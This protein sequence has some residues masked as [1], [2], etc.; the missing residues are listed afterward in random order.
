MITKSK[1]QKCLQ[2]LRMSESMPTNLDDFYIE[3]TISSCTLSKKTVLESE[4]YLSV[5][6][7]T[8]QIY[9]ISPSKAGIYLLYDLHKNPHYHL[10]HKERSSVQQK[11]T[12]LGVP[13]VLLDDKSY[14]EEGR[15]HHHTHL[16]PLYKEKV[17]PVITKLDLD[18]IVSKLS[19][20]EICDRGNIA[21]TFGWKNNAFVKSNGV[22]VPCNDTLDDFDRTVLKIMTKSYMSAYGDNIANP[23]FTKNE[24]RI[25]EY[26]NQLVTIG[27]CV[28]SNSSIENVFES[29]TYALTFCSNNSNT[30]LRPH[31]DTLNC[32][33]TGFNAVF[34]M[35]F[36][37]RHPTEKKF[38][39]L[40][41]LGYSRRSIFYAMN[42]F[43]K[44]S[45][46]KNHLK[47]YS[48]YLDERN[49][50]CLEN[51]IPWND[52]R[53]KTPSIISKIPFIDKC[54]F[55]SIFVSGLYDII[56][57]G[58][59]LFL[60]DIVELVL[61]IGWLCT[62]ANYY[63][64]LS[65]WNSNGIPKGNLTVIM[66]R[67]LVEQF[68]G[69]SRGEGLRMQPSC[70]SP[71]PL[72]KIY[73]GQRILLR[74]INIA[75]GSP[76]CDIKQGME[77][78]EK[79]YYVRGLGAQHLMSV[80]TLLRVVYNPEYVRSTVLLETN[81]T[82]KK[83]HDLYRLNHKLTNE[84][85][86][87]LSMELYDGCSRMV[88]NLV[89]EFFRDIHENPTTFTWDLQYY[90]DSIGKRKL[91]KPDTFFSNQSIFKETQFAIHRYFYDKHGKVKSEFLHNL[92]L[93]REAHVRH[94][95]I[96]KNVTTDELVYVTK[97]QEEGGHG[98]KS[99]PGKK[100]GKKSKC[101]KSQS[102]KTS[103]KKKVS[104]D[105]DDTKL[106]DDGEENDT[107][108]QGEGETNISSSY[109][110]RNR[111]IMYTKKYSGIQ[112]Q[113]ISMLKDSCDQESVDCRDMSWFL[114][115]KKYI[116]SDL[117]LRQIIGRT[118]RKRKRNKAK[119]S[120]VT[121]ILH[122][123]NNRQV[124]SQ[125]INGQNKVH[126]VRSENMN[127]CQKGFY[128]LYG[129]VI[130]KNN[131]CLAFYETKKDALL[132]LKMTIFAGDVP[133]IVSNCDLSS[134][135][136]NMEPNSHMALLEKKQGVESFFGFI[137][138][139]DTCYFMNIPLEDAMTLKGEW[140]EFKCYTE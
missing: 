59:T 17:S 53:R 75:N 94:W 21:L 24:K 124:Y 83:I 20:E 110:L 74:F 44:R 98:L 100:I 108:Y 117:C 138:K 90:D 63:R 16:S 135:L 4:G 111:N 56:K 127:I 60:E 2:N 123:D 52:A 99:L 43:E 136:R 62:G 41:L 77:M 26:A 126:F 84:L 36:I 66:L 81:L 122:H 102:R 45:M 119:G 114:G 40:V 12:D 54:G 51:A 55:Y 65:Q 67:T 106:L 42:R 33:E 27:T 105:I 104:K 73:E 113:I 88:E 39:R 18:A 72:E 31:V 8:K 131:L 57:S 76:S 86:K 25:R 7:R 3:S 109:M 101:L 49:D 30:Q 112:L 70:N 129:Q 118:S 132:A 91:K 6:W 134:L 140:Q 71:I 28:S 37:F 97:K 38:V 5:R 116:N 35:Y 61:P 78:L 29:V 96:E 69:I 79:I 121:D 15:I 128:G 23:P 139:K 82:A 87:E 58:K 103:S 32:F 137:S 130:S 1:H 85:Y 14:V 68:D 133:N 125:S 22:N 46:F 80:L 19:K 93:D 50:F 48:T 11:S 95:L 89:C 107:L 9:C 34:G 47:R 92:V 120:L 64:V 115:E 10:Q 13:F